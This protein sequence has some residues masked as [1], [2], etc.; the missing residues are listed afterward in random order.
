MVVY[1]CLKHH[2][3]QQNIDTTGNNLRNLTFVTLNIRNV[4]LTNWCRNNFKL[5]NFVVC[6]SESPWGQRDKKNNRRQI[7]KLSDKVSVLIYN[8]FSR[9]GTNTSH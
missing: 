7:S 5:R 4:N 1:L 6:V 3:T 8:A 2:I 9:N